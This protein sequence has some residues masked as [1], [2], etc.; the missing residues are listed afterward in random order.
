M[1]WKFLILC[2]LAWI[3]YKKMSKHIWSAQISFAVIAVKE[4]SFVMDVMSNGTLGFYCAWQKLGA[5]LS[6]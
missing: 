3:Y 5:I 6:K 1:E 4:I 2:N